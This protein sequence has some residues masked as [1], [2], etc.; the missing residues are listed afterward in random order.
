MICG[1]VEDDFGSCFDSLY[2]PNPD[3]SNS[4][5][6]ATLISKINTEDLITLSPREMTAGHEVFEEQSRDTDWQ[7]HPIPPGGNYFWQSSIGDIPQQD[8]LNQQHT[9]PNL[10]EHDQAK[11]DFKIELKTT[12]GGKSSWYYS[13]KMKKVYIRMDQ[14]IY[15]QVQYLFIAKTE[16]EPASL[17]V[18]MVFQDDIGMPVKRCNNHK[19]SGMDA[20]TESHN[21][22]E[23]YIESVVRCVN[24][25]AKYVGSAAGK[26]VNERLAVLIPLS[27][28]APDDKNITKQ[29]IALKFLCQNSCIG[30]R[31]TAVI[32]FL[33]NKDGVVLGKRFLSV[34]ICSC[35]KRDKEKEESKCNELKRSSDEANLPPGKRLS[36]KIKEEPEDI[37]HDSPT[38]EVEQANDEEIRME[39]AVP[40]KEFM[41]DVYN[42]CFA[43]ITQR[44]ALDPNSNKYNRYFKDLKSKVLAKRGGQ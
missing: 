24:P 21:F 40:D 28:V 29:S 44:M 10:E 43:M 14:T 20:A 31:P 32:F 38:S 26:N 19:A 25:H 27:P 3:G 4:D 12:N 30:R 8:A 16:T 6:S 18:M 22:G 11:L 13:E 17:R 15:L 41:D 2:Q 35:P 1:A 9:F 37:S 34:K 42:Y 23:A 33:E 5:D 39:I 36:K 7:S